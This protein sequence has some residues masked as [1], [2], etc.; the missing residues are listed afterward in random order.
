MVVVDV[1]GPYDEAAGGPM[2]WRGRAA[3][4]EFVKYTLDRPNK[5]GLRPYEI[6]EERHKRIMAVETWSDI[7][8][9][10]H[11]RV[12][13]K[14]E[15][16]LEWFGSIGVVGRPITPEP[17]PVLDPMLAFLR[18]APF[19][20]HRTKFGAPQPLLELNEMMALSASGALGKNTGY[21][22]KHNQ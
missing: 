20:P 4:P 14:F 5:R 10:N 7:D 1:T 21:V 18:E 8:R 16:V 13:A 15:E 12:R 2:N 11:P 9:P 17:E 3:H 19:E 6:A 22:F